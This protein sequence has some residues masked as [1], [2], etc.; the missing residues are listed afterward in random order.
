MHLRVALER[1]HDR[2]GVNV[3]SHPPAPWAMRSKRS[4]SSKFRSPRRATSGPA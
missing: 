1:L 3:K 4:A 2:F